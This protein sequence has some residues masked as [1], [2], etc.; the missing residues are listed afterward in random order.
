[1]AE[2][3]FDVEYGNR[4]AK[5]VRIRNTDKIKLWGNPHVMVEVICGTAFLAGGRDN[6]RMAVATANCV[7]E[8]LGTRGVWRGIVNNRKFKAVDVSFKGVTK[9]KALTQK[10]KACSSRRPKK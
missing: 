4:K 9:K 10:R 6:Y 7:L 2:A 3:I 8:T 1:M 5:G